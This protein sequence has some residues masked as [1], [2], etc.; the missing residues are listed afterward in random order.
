MITSLAAILTRPR[1]EEKA[2]LGL[3]LVYAA[4]MAG[5]EAT[6][7]GMDD[8][9]YNFLPGTGYPSEM[10]VNYLKESGRAVA[11]AE[12]LAERRLD[13]ASLVAGVEVVPAAQLN[14]IL[15]D[16]QANLVF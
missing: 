1:G 10:L 7:L 2:V 12:S 4:H 14:D 11:V 3:R 8:G 16:C 5:L 13:P 6:L 9:V 15:E